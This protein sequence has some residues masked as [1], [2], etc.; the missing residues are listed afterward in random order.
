[1]Q[2]DRNGK[3]ILIEN[4]IQRSP[5]LTGIQSGKYG[6][7]MRPKNKKPFVWHL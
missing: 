3:G 4:A 7:A 6:K 1:V 5:F 2:A